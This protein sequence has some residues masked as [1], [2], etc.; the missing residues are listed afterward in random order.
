MVRGFPNVR[1]MLA[2]ND[3][4]KGNDVCGSRPVSYSREATS[5]FPALGAELVLLR[6][7]WSE[8]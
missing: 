3:H 1:K 7:W 8:W 2:L 4:K 6:H 5:G